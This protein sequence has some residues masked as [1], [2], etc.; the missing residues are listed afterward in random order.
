VWL[1]SAGGKANKESLQSQK[2]LQNAYIG[3]VYSKR[4]PVLDAAGSPVP[5]ALYG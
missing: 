5:C 1:W 3:F 4:V 2:I